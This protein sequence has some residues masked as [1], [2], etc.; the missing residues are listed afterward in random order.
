MTAEHYAGRPGHPLGS[1]VARV[2]PAYQ[3]RLLASSAVDFDDLLVHT[4][5]LLHENPEVRAELDARYRY[6]MVDEYQDTNS[7]R[8]NMPRSSGGV[9]GG[10]SESG[11]DR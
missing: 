5:T 1:I 7:W 10:L 9:V 2:Y 6:V 4:V 11:R 8:S 3:A